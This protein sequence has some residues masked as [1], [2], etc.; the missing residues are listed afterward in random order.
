LIIGF[1]RKENNM[2]RLAA[3]T[4]GK[5]KRGIDLRTQ[6][7]IYPAI[8]WATTMSYEIDFDRDLDYVSLSARGAL[9]M[10][11]ARACWGK[12]QEIL[13][14]YDRTRVLVDTTNVIA[15]LSAIENYKF[16]K[17][18]MHEFPSILSVALVVSP[19]RTTLGRFIETAA[20]NNGV[21]LKSFA[22]MYE[23]IVWLSSLN[24]R[25]A[26]LHSTQGRTR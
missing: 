2:K 16:I 19:E 8:V 26:E 9:N 21:R 22:D 4:I 12:L 20:V 15:K 13:R 1:F 14:V 24:R 23:A 6:D 3:T 10:S 11:E 25:Q 7:F 18:L 17:E 5:R